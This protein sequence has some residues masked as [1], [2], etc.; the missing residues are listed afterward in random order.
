LLV[1]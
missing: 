1:I